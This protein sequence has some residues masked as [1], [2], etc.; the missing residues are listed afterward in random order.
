MFAYDKLKNTFCFS[1]LKPDVWLWQGG[2]N[3]ACSLHLRPQICPTWIYL[4]EIQ[5]SYLL[6][7]HYDKEVTGSVNFA[8]GIWLDGCVWCT[9]SYIA[10]WM[11]DC[12]WSDKT[13]GACNVCELQ[14]HTLIHAKCKDKFWTASKRQN[15][16]KQI[17][18]PNLQ[19][20]AGLKKRIRSVRFLVKANM[21][22]APLACQNCENTG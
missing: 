7:D 16:R 2:K 9:Q 21:C 3:T 17:C 6:S 8:F 12:Q 15:K 10:F 4:K 11:L 20:I 19:D 5:F 1:D 22:H 18:T 14:I 13:A